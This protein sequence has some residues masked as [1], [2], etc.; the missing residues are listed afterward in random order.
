ME[1]NESLPIEII[2]K[3][4]TQIEFK[5]NLDHNYD[6][7]FN[8]GDGFDG[9]KCWLNIYHSNQTD[10]TLYENWSFPTNEVLDAFFFD[11][12]TKALLN[13]YG[14]KIGSESFEKT[15]LKVSFSKVR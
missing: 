5:N 10:S 9:I 7:Q 6:I 4:I 12:N 8:L 1:I 14:F 2:N 11:I 15:H 13:T 3:N